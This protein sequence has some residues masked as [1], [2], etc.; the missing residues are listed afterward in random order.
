MILNPTH[1]SVFILFQSFLLSKYSLTLVPYLY[2]NHL[3]CLEKGMATY[4]S[5]FAWRI[6]WTE[7]FGGL[8]SIGSQ[9]SNITE[10]HTHTHPS[11]CYFLW[12]NLCLSSKSKS[13]VWNL[14]WIP[15][16]FKLK[17]KLNN[18]LLSIL[19]ENL[20]HTLGLK[21]SWNHQTWI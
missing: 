19:S 9:E 10:K 2:T 5:I 16:F 14:T 4:P 21:N 1:S 11:S 7:E 3:S 20:R 8:Q 15:Q 18:Y 13:E 6:P 17:I 12:T